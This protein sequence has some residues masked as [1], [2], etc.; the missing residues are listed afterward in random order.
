MP[1]VNWM[2]CCRSVG[3][4]L[5]GTPK[6][7]LSGP[8]GDHQFNDKPAE[9]RSAAKPKLLS[10]TGVY[11]SGQPEAWILAGPWERKIVLEVTEDLP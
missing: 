9:Y 5:I 8:T 3:S 4:F 10:H 2:R 1:S 11:E 7:S 6:L